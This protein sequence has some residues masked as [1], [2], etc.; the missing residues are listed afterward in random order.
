MEALIE[1]ANAISNYI[2]RRIIFNTND[3]CEITRFAIFKT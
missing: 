3:P 1:I 2:A